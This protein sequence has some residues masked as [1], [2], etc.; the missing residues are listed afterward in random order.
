MLAC[1]FVSIFSFLNIFRIFQCVSVK[2]FLTY[3]PC[4][5]DAFGRGGCEKGMD[6]AHCKVIPRSVHPPMHQCTNALIFFNY[7][8]RGEMGCLPSWLLGF[9]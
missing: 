1:L 5:L 8:L 2:C 4:T 3:W 6:A 7:R 9:C